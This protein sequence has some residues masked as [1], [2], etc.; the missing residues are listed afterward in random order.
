MMICQMEIGRKKRRKTNRK[1]LIDFKEVSDGRRVSYG[2]TAQV[3]PILL[4]HTI[5]TRRMLRFGFSL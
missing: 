4:D 3:L 1:S 2:G 5:V